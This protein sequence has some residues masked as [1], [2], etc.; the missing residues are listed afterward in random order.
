M[1]ILAILASLFAVGLLCWLVFTLAVFAL[2]AFVGVTT[3]AW[4]N[5][6][7]AGI[8]G[9]V[10]VGALAAA[11]T[12]AIG[13]LLIAFVRPMWLKLLVAIAFVAPAAVAGF[14]AT[15]G[16]VKHLMPSEGW[17]IAFSIIGAAAVGITAFVRVAGM[18]ATPGPSSRDLARA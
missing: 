6:S 3:G 5:E 4:A 16:I 14:H 1:I 9:A 7:G 8:A 2:P 10:V 13:H 11:M 17:Q 12:L 18:A 15:H